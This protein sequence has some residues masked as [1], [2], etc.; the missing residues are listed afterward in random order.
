LI[1]HVHRQFALTGGIGHLAVDRFVIGGGNR[2]HHLIQM[3]WLESL[4]Q[5][6]NPAMGQFLGQFRSELRGHYRYLGAS[7][8]QQ[9]GLACRDISAAYYQ[10]GLVANV[11]EYRE[12]VHLSVFF[13]E[14]DAKIQHCGQCSMQ[15]A[16]AF[17]VRPRFR[18]L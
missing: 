13:H 15:L 7:L 2:Q 5:M 12:I 11:E 1:D 14:S 16:C 17:L 3:L 9:P 10:A 8:G 6:L 18:L 4:L